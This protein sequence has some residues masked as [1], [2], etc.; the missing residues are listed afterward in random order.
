MKG[1]APPLLGGRGGEAARRPSLFFPPPCSSLT[2]ILL[3]FP[4]NAAG[5]RRGEGGNLVDNLT[6]FPPAPARRRVGGKGRPPAL[7]F[8]RCTSAGAV[9][10]AGKRRTS[11][12]SDD[13]GTG[14]GG[15][16]LATAGDVDT[17]IAGP[18]VVM[19]PVSQRGGGASQQ[20]AIVD[21]DSDEPIVVH[22]I[23]LRRPS[24]PR[25][26]APP[27]QRPQLLQLPDPRLRR[28]APRPHL[29]RRRRPPRA[30]GRG[31]TA[32]GARAYLHRNSKPETPSSVP[33]GGAGRA[34]LAPSSPDRLRDCCAVNVEARVWKRPAAG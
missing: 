9:G 21:P 31:R 18:Q 15:P 30:R 8:E 23:P 22:S 7:A 24:F 27:T 3:L 32:A 25:T 13:G 14:P 29:R 20:Q 5:W 2:S 26:W 33:G 10:G 28:G 1:A 16:A 12:T 11:G 34:P 6:R 4:Q 17:T 19:L